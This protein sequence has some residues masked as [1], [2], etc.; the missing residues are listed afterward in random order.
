MKMEMQGLARPHFVAGIAAIRDQSA[1][2]D[3]APFVPAQPF[4]QAVLRI[5]RMLAL[6]H[7]LLCAIQLLQP[8][9]KPSYSRG[10]TDIPI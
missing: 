4:Q 2:S 7:V 1:S 3:L 8:G 9:Y 6:L 5:L 10:G